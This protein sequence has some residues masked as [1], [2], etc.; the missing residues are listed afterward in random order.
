M[1]KILLEKMLD[2]I[3]FYW[4]HNSTS[5]KNNSL[6]GHSKEPWLNEVCHISCQ[7]KYSWHISCNRYRS[8]HRRCSVRK[9]VLR[10]FA[11]FTRK[12][13]C[14]S[15]FFNRNSQQSTCA[16]VS[17][18]INFRPQPATLFKNRLWHCCFP[19]N[20]AKFIRTPFLQNTTGRLLL[21]IL[22]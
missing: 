1:I 20:F 2:A 7:V 19:V 13:L 14:Q 18:L 6:N 11:K 22:C 4:F 10:N 3:Y 5:E 9:G 17:F 12:N 8:S 21:L 16:R 15:L